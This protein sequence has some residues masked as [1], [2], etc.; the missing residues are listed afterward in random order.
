MMGNPNTRK[1]LTVKN[2]TQLMFMSLGA[3]GTDGDME[4]STFL[5]NPLTSP[6]LMVLASTAASD[7]TNRDDQQRLPAHNFSGAPD[8]DV[9]FTSAAYPMFRQEGFPPLYAPMHMPFVQHPVAHLNPSATGAFRPLQSS[10]GTDD[11]EP[12]HSAFLPAK[13][14]KL[15]ESDLNR[16]YNDSSC[17]DKDTPENL[18]IHSLNKEDRNNTTPNS[19][20]YDISS[21]GLSES[22]DSQGRHT[23]S[24]EGRHLR[25]SIRK[26]FIV[27]GQFPC[28]PVCGLTLRIGEVE[29]HFTSELEKLEKIT[30][31]K[32][33]KR[34]PSREGTPLGGR[35]LLPSPSNTKSKSPPPEVAAQSRHETYQRVKANRNNRLN[36]RIRGRKKRHQE[37]TTC[38]VCNKLVTGTPEE[39]SDHVD[40][41][42]K[43]R[44]QEEE[45]LVDIEGDEQYEEYTWCGQTRIRA[46]SM[47]E[48]GLKASGFKTSSR[49]EDDDDVNLDVDGDDGDVYGRPQYGEADVIP[50]NL[51]EPLEE[52]ERDA[53][54]GAYMRTEVN[55]VSS[56]SP[57]NDMNRW[58]IGENGDAVPSTSSAN[59]RVSCGS[60]ASEIIDSL[61]SKIRQQEDSLKKSDK[62]K[63]LICMD[64]YTVPLVSVHCWHV[65]CEECWLRTLGSKKLCPQCNMITSPSDL[66]KI[67]L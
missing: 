31:L 8:K 60:A 9:P 12:Y 41:C 24:D 55:S 33:S 5:P 46:S 14:S 45:L 20:S 62:N 10:A 2:S 52:K 51:D 64:Q 29:S 23:P 44:E 25:R 59:E 6:A 37:E 48:G 47:L 54:R 61:K 35:K 11:R 17:S 18:V 38:P 13:R 27:D 4:N 1:R 66:R 34:T 22:G 42:L 32:N 58:S 28:C 49:G 50:C 43:K 56:N 57:R 53:L 26:K 40:M 67:Y 30:S 63:C 39:L 65:H 16:L 15:R 3:A 36:S 7:A 19:L 21:E